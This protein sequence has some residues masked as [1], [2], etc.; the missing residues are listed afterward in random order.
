MHGDSGDKIQFNLFVHLSS[1]SR[2]LIPIKLST[3]TNKISIKAKHGN[4][5]ELILHLTDVIVDECVEINR[6]FQNYEYYSLCNLL[7]S[8]QD[9]EG[10]FVASLNQAAFM[11]NLLL[12]LLLVFLGR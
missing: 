6:P 2:N 3:C 9:S 11:N 1:I 7:S 4:K 10:F 8:K 5:C 12:L